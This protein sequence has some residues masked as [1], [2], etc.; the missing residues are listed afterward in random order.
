MKEWFTDKNYYRKKFN[1]AELN[2]EVAKHTFEE[3]TRKWTEELLE[4]GIKIE[5]L[6]KQLKAERTKRKKIEKKYREGEQ[7]RRKK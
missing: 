6:K 4:K 5:H 7:P 3:A 2:L 1:E